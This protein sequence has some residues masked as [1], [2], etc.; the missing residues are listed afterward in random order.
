MFVIGITAIVFGII[1]II[2]DIP[3]GMKI[4]GVVLGSASLGFMIA[5]FLLLRYLDYI[6]PVY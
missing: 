4:A 3:L 2:K 5:G 6:W 1:G